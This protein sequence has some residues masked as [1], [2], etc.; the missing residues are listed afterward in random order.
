MLTLSVTW[1]ELNGRLL[2]QR[3]RTELFWSALSRG[4][5]SL[6]FHSF[7]GYKLIH[8]HKIHYKS[9][10]STA[11]AVATF[12][13]SFLSLCWIHSSLV[14]RSFPAGQS[15][16]SLSEWCHCF[17]HKGCFFLTDSVSSSLKRLQVADLW[18]PI[19]NSAYAISFYSEN[20]ICLSTVIHV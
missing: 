9:W 14:I 4:A 15:E 8:V 1:Q 13:P 2:R 18:L 6:V 3:T 16:W 20:L 12:N 10:N 11:P 7:I 17:A 19:S 5:Y